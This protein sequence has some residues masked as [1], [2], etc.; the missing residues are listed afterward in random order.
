MRSGDEALQKVDVAC[1]VEIRE[2]LLPQT[3]D[4]HL[5]EMEDSQRRAQVVGRQ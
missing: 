5:E 2:E 4:V 3:F 1:R